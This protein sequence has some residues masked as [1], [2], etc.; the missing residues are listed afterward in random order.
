MTRW[1]LH[2]NPGLPRVLREAGMGFLFIVFL[3]LVQGAAQKIEEATLAKWERKPM[4]VAIHDS[5]QEF[6]GTP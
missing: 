3:V 4:R 2:M 5:T 6:Y 1:A